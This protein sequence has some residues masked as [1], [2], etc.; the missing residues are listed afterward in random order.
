MPELPGPR[1][2]RFQSKFGLSLADAQLLAG[3]RGLGD[4]FEQVAMITGN[5][6]S[7]ANWVRGDLLGK[8]NEQNLN[9]SESP[10]SPDQ[11]G[12]LIGLID[13]DIIS[14]KTAKTVF[15]ALWAGETTQPAEYVKAQGLEQVSD[16]GAIEPL[17]E[18][19]L[20][21]HPKQAE[22]LRAGKDKLMGFFVGKVMQATGGKANPQQVNAMIRQKLSP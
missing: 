19:L 21:E 3:D 1:S 20:A 4:F 6:R 8:L 10:V 12:A 11:M 15:A 17:I 16:A 22:D 5:G 18:T 7:A 2:V 9:I 14:G 13:D